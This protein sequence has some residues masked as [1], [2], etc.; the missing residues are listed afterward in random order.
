[1]HKLTHA[2]IDACICTCIHTYIHNTEISRTGYDWPEK[3]TF[4]QK[5]Q[6]NTA[7]STTEYMLTYNFVVY[8][9]SAKVS[10]L[11]NAYHW[12]FNSWSKLYMT[13]GTPVT[14]VSFATIMSH[15]N[16]Q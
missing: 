9:S 1:M 11:K 12:M 8:A 3:A 10:D 13:L 4:I 2:Y 15:C 14:P 16:L 6:R 5:S 7:S